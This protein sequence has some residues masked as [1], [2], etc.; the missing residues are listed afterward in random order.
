[1]VLEDQYGAAPAR[2]VLGVVIANTMT[3][4]RSA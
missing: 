2:A 3:P 1:M 4:T